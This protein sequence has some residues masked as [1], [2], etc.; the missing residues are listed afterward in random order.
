MLNII[1][2]FL[3]PT[4]EIVVHIEAFAMLE[5]FN[6]PTWARDV[7]NASAV[8]FVFEISYLYLAEHIIAC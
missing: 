6:V 5:T 3:S 8:Y 4:E 7:I 1:L 2:L